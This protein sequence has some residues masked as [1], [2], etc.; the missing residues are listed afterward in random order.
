MYVYFNFTQDTKQTSCII[1][2]VKRDT[3]YILGCRYH[4]I[5]QILIK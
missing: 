1:I 2:V 5:I 3:I 4:T